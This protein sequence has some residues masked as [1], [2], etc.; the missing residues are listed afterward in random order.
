MQLRNLPDYRLL[1]LAAVAFGLTVDDTMRQL[2]RFEGSS[3]WNPLTND[4]D[5]FRLGVKLN[6]GFR[7]LAFHH[8]PSHEIEVSLGLTTL[9]TEKANGDPYAAARRAIV[10]AAAEIGLVILGLDTFC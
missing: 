5:A 4:G 3:V 6:L 1:E 8:Q 9:V 10:Y 2:W 7:P